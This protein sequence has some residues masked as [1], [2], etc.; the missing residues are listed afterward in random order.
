M[1]R[2]GARRRQVDW[3]DCPSSGRP[4][5]KLWIL[6]ATL[7]I[8]AMIGIPA[9]ADRCTQ[10]SEPIETDRPDVTNSSVVIPVG[11]SEREWGQP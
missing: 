8:I 7:M 5:G 4:H 1:K 9:P 11:P 3:S 2:F 10:T 6:V